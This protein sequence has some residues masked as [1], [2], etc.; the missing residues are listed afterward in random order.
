MQLKTTEK[1]WESYK[2]HSVEFLK[3]NKIKLIYLAMQATRAFGQKILFRKYLI[4]MIFLP[5]LI[6]RVTERNPDRLL[7]RSV[8]Y[9]SFITVIIVSIL[10]LFQIWNNKN[11]REV[12]GSPGTHADNV[13]IRL[14]ANP[15]QKRGTKKKKSAEQS[16]K[17]NSKRKVCFL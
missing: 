11:K 1:S 14:L 13:K 17:R 7:F 10:L 5:K 16:P 2:N 6:I 15:R 9:N 3:N 12:R 4:D 8:L